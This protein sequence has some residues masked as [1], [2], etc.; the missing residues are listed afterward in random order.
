MLG[1]LLGNYDTRTKLDNDIHRML[2]KKFGEEWVFQ[3]TINRSVRHREAPVYS[4]T[5]FEHAPGELAAEQF[6]ALTHEVLTRLEHAQ[7]I[8]E[9]T[10]A[11]LTETYHG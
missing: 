10:E 8:R 5:I 6:L 4:R 3:T 7:E 1:V 2:A 11:E 9:N